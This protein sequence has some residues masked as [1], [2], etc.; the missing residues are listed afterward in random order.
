MRSS[1]NTFAYIRK[2]RICVGRGVLLNVTDR[3][4]IAEGSENVKDAATC[5]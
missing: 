5:I 2:C 4:N 3:D 1:C